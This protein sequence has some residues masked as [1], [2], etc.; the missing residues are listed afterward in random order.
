MVGAYTT[1]YEPLLLLA[2]ASRYS[3]IKT[4]HGYG[5][6]M[7]GVTAAWNVVLAVWMRIGTLLPSKDHG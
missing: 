7:P 1:A 4:Q 5:R 6:A 3:R 2:V